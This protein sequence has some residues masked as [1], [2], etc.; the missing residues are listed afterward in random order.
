[1]S[2]L[3]LLALMLFSGGSYAANG[4]IYAGGLLGISVPDHDDTSARPLYGILGGARIGGEFAFGAYYLVANKSETISGVKTDF[5]YS[6]YGLQGAYYFEAIDENAFIA[7]RV[8]ISKVEK[9]DKTY[10]P[11]H[12]GLVAGYDYFVNEKFSFGPEVGFLFVHGEDTTG[13]QLEGF[14]MLNFAA[15]AKFWF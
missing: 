5:N 14:S 10:S 7:A 15:T 12:W 3:L 6:L 11:F 1:M 8:G 4:K 9:G 2:R 13:A